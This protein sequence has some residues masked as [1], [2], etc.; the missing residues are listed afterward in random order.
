MKLCIIEYDQ[1]DLADLTDEEYQ[2]LLGVKKERKKEKC[3]SSSSIYIYCWK[4]QCPCAWNWREH[5]VVTRVKNQGMCGSCWVFS[6]FASMQS[7]YA[8][9]TSKLESLSEQELVDCTNE[10]EMSHGFIEVIE[11]HGDKLT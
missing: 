10:G 11:N 9:A 7:V 3:S 2:N 8:R 6:V 5:D 4:W 1:I